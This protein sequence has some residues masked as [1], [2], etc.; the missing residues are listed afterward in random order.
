M[1]DYGGLRPAPADRFS[2]EEEVRLLSLCPG[3]I[4]EP[5]VRTHANT[6]PVWGNFCRMRY[7]WA[8]DPA[9]RFRA[10]TAGALTALAVHILEQG[11]AEF[12]L[13][14]GPHPNR[15][16]RSRWILSE[17]PRQVIA[18]TGSRYGPTAPLG[19]LMKALDRGVPFAIVAKPCDL[20][21]VY[22]LSKAD[23]RVDALCTIRMAMVCG[24][25]SRLTKSQALL[26]ENG[27]KEEEVT[28]FR[29]R[30][31]GNPGRLRVETRDGRAFEKTYREL[32]QDER[33]WEL[34]TRCKLCPD[35]LGEAADIAA[36]DVWP[37]GGPTGEDAGFNGLIV[38]SEVGEKLVA[39]A[40]KTGALVIG[41]EITPREF[42]AL[43]PHQVRKKEALSARFQGLRESGAPVIDTPGLRIE[44]LG[45]NLDMESREKQIEGTKQRFQAGRIKEPLPPS[46]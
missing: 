34:E 5:R 21:A 13:H 1:T 19:G 36:S 26:N 24:G 27:I 11:K 10:A 40:A 33:D 30:G 35:A 23:P 39:S 29:Y 42:D 46:L 18:N 45:K 22:Q 41:E 15:P 43:Q 17:T 38:R 25:Q 9:I 7:A 44:E 31:Y 8:G 12:I 32:W 6:D 20:G 2:S 3:V 4:A 37:G 16:M 14:T 28:L